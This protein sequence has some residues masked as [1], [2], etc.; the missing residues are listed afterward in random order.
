MNSLISTVLSE[1]I[2]VSGYAKKD[3]AVKYVPNNQKLFVYNENTNQFEGNE[4]IPPLREY[5]S[6]KNQIVVA[7]NDPL[8]LKHGQDNFANFLI[9]ND[10]IFSPKAVKAISK[11]NSS[12]IDGLTNPYQTVAL[13]IKSIQHQLLISQVLRIVLF[14][15]LFTS[16]IVY[17]LSLYRFN[18][19]TF[20]KK[21]ILGLSSFR[22]YSVYVLPLILVNFLT[23]FITKILF[24]TTGVPL[25]IFVFS[26]I[27]T[28]ITTIIFNFLIRNDYAAIIKGSNI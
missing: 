23:Y 17:I 28:I 27:L 9:N 16:I 26:V 14:I 13:N 4:N 2:S 3:I 22:I 11:Y 6:L 19:N 18:F 25:R 15:S 5:G 20:V 12:L 7:L 24:I 10:T 8:L 21:K 1:F